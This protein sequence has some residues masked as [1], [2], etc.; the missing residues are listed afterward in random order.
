MNFLKE[1]HD[2]L[3]DIFH[4]IG[5]LQELIIFTTTENIILLDSPLAIFKY[6]INIIKAF[7]IIKVDWIIDLDTLELSF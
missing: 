2:I 3:I 4:V 7:F 5:L 6:F 1:H